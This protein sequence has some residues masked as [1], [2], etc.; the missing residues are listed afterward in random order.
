MVIPGDNPA[1][2]LAPAT[3]FVSTAR[4]LARFFAQLD[5]AANESVLAIASRREMIRHQW[6]NPHFSFERYYGLGIYSGKLA[7]WEWFGHNGAFPG[8]V[9]RT[10]VLP[11]PGLAVSVVT[12]AADGLADRWLEG[13]IHIL[14][15]F[16][17]HGAPTGE[18]RDWTG[19]WWTRWVAIDL[20]AMGGK[21]MVG[22]PA[23]PNPFADASQISVS[24]P[25]CGHISLATGF[26]HYGEPVRRIRGAD[27]NVEEVWLGSARFQPEAAV[28]AELDQHYRG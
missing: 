14:A 13:A 8:F 1:N 24:S 16:A 17:K 11:D 23:L 22:S 19:R 9:S 5:P 27:G 18:V 7:D 15:S 20:V 28:A 6:R 3:G 4:D 21:V 10:A 26:A 2:A 12:N 25:D